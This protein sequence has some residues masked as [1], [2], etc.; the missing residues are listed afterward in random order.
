MRKAMVCALA[1]A[2]LVGCKKSDGNVIQP[3]GTGGVYPGTGGVAPGTGGVAPGTGGVT[4]GTGGVTPG[5]GGVGGGGGTAGMGGGAPVAGCSAADTTAAPA[6]LHMAA[7]DVLASATTCAFSSCHAGGN[8]RAHLNLLNVADIRTAMVGVA[9]CEAPNLP[10]VDGSGGDAALNHSY[11]W[12]KLTAPVMLDASLTGDP[13]WGMNLT[14]NQ[15]AGQPYGIRM[16]NSGTAM[17]WEEAR[18]AAVRN[19]ICAGAPGP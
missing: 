8:P 14:C 4:P 15:N 10:L 16:P 9:S 19:W 18:L 6:A 7:H 13:A 2:A 5:T 12:L 1:L 3:G 11:L 17:L